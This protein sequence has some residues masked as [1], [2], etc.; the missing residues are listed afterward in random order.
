MYL[1]VEFSL[2]SKDNDAALIGCGLASQGLC[3]RCGRETWGFRILYMRLLSICG[4]SPTT[5]QMEYLGRGLE[6]IKT[7]SFICRPPVAGPAPF[8][9]KRWGH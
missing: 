4:R 3:A 1:E 6:D 9:I 8:T 7:V 2:S 5:R